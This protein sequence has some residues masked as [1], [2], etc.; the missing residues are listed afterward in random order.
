[1]EMFMELFKNFI[2]ENGVEILG[3]IITAI[4]GYIGI[5]LKNL[6]TK[7]IN[8]KTKESVVKTCVQAIEQL[9]KDLHGEEKLNKVIE[10]AT[11]MLSEKG[12]TITDLELRMLIESA[13]GEFNDN[14]KST[15]VEGETVEV[16]EDIIEEDIPTGEAVG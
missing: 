2:S 4:A 1:M 6:Y 16:V 13:V 8:D 9:Y 7:H 15:T 14:F 3:T 12:I 11:D 5:V 10:S